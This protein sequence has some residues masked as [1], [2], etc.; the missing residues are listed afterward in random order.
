MYQQALHEDYVFMVDSHM[1]ADMGAAKGSVWFSRT[2]DIVAQDRMFGDP[3]IEWIQMQFL[4]LTEWRPCKA[5]VAVDSN[6]VEAVE[7]FEITVDPTLSFKMLKR[8]GAARVY[9]FDRNTL[10]ITVVPDPQVPG[11]WVILRIEEEIEAD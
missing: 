3:S 6:R 5:M 8:G 9:T 10:W 11:S 1:A 7:G 4:P 2:G